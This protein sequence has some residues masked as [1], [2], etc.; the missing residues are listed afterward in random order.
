[1]ATAMGVSLEADPTQL[2]LEMTTA[3]QETQSQKTQLSP[4]RIP[5]HRNREVIY[6]LF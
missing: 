2:I 6:T 5:T 1:M 3:L 4:G